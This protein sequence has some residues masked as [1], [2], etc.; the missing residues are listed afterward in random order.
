MPDGCRRQPR[1]FSTRRTRERRQA[2]HPGRP[3][4]R[5]RDRSSGSDH[6]VDGSG[7]VGFSPGLIPSADLL[8][9]V[10]F[11]TPPSLAPLCRAGTS[12]SRGSHPNSA[13]C[14]LVVWLGLA[15]NWT[16][17]VV[18]GAGIWRGRDAQGAG[19]GAAVAEVSPVLVCT[20]PDPGL[21]L[22]AARRA[23]SLYRL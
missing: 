15:M 14:L 12:F 11:G 18:L 2:C 22:T 10:H 17:A 3:V 23:G 6:W 1:C 8:P 20:R 9:S 7:P 4:R 13:C 19:T 5:R 21:T 16:G